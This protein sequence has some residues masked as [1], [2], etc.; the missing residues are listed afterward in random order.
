MGTTSGTTIPIADSQGLL[1]LKS[2]LGI[3]VRKSSHIKNTHSAQQWK[4]LC[5]PEPVLAP[6]V[7]RIPLRLT[8]ARGNLEGYGVRDLEMNEFVGSHLKTGSQRLG[9][10]C[11]VEGLVEQCA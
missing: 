3:S 8:R 6:S 11:L 4:P 7:T 1:T 9:A 2:Y 10:T 5:H